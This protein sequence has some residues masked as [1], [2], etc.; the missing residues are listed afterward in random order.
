M[1]YHTYD[2]WCAPRHR[3][4]PPRCGDVHTMRGAPL[5]TPAVRALVPLFRGRGAGHTCGRAATQNRRG[6][7]PCAVHVICYQRAAHPSC[8]A[9]CTATLGATA[10]IPS[11]VSCPHTVAGLRQFGSLPTGGAAAAV[12]ATCE[13]LVP[14]QRPSGHACTPP[15]PPPP[16][17]SS[18]ARCHGPQPSTA[19]MRRNPFHATSGGCRS[20]HGVRA[21]AL[22][23][24][25]GTPLHI[26]SP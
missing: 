11:A 19:R 17:R 15:P 5:R 7:A 9:A 18:P 12:G 26:A 10:C 6:H 16:H 2:V 14:A 21:C 13:G 20:T 23:A 25:R 8:P 4:P 24:R 1:R 3:R 22:V